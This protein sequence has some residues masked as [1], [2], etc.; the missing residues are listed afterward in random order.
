MLL[1]K[2]V[3]LITALL[4]SACGYHLRGPLVLPGGQKNVY[5]EGGSEK[6]R[7]QFSGLL[8]ASSIKLG[9]SPEKAGIV[10]KILDEDSQRRALSLNA[11]GAANNFELSYHIDFELLDSKNKLLIPSQPIEIKRQY[12]NDQ[13]AVLAKGNEETLIR[14]EMYQQAVRSIINRAK[15]ALDEDPK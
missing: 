13:L 6:L 4:L 10:V 11:G 3:I 8:G 9:S 14:N 1:K 12:Y 15:F 2:L 5:L 7:E